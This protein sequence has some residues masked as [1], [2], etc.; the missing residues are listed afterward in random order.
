[1]KKILYFTADWCGPCKMIKPQLIAASKQLPITFV[2][3]DTS[4]S[5]ASYYNVRNIPCVIL[6]DEFG[7]ERGRLVGNSISVQSITELYN[8]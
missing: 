8:K 7:S 2:N 5:Q 4:S 6:V 1:M 3:I